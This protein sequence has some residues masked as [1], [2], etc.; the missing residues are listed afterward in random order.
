MAGGHLGGGGD[1]DHRGARQLAPVEGH[2]PGLV[3]QAALLLVRGI[4]FFIH[5]HQPQAGQRGEDG[6]AGP[7]HDI[8]FSHHDAAPLIHPEGLG[9]T[10]VE[11]G[12]PGAEA[13]PEGLGHGVGQGDLRRQD[14]DLTSLPGGRR[15][16]KPRFCRWP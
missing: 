13:S 11:Q 1:Q 3:E 14:Q 16:G 9:Q 5:H 7:H 6:G 2:V 12:D 15:S 4:V 10:A 8:H